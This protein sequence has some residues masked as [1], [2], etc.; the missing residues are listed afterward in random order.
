MKHGRMRQVYVCLVL[1]C[2]LVGMS[3]VV[4]AADKVLELRNT[5]TRMIWVAKS[6]SYVANYANL[7]WYSQKAGVWSRWNVTEGGYLYYAYARLN[8]PGQ[9][10]TVFYAQLPFHKHYRWFWKVASNGS[11]LYLTADYERAKGKNPWQ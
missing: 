5:T 10:E 2:F 1:F 11:K 9:R 4:F 8:D 3:T 7:Q 6:N